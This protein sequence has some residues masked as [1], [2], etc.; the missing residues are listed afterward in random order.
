MNLIT[1]GR[2]NFVLTQLAMTTNDGISSN[3]VTR[4][5]MRAMGEDSIMNPLADASARDAVPR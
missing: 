5:A 2:A 3:D 4:F 1:V